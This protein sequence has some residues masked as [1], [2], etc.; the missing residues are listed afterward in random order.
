[1][2]TAVQLPMDRPHKA[3]RRLRVRLIGLLFG[4]CG[5]SAVMADAG[6]ELKD[7]PP[8]HSESIVSVRAV[9]DGAM[10]PDEAVSTFRHIDRLFPT[11]TIAHG[12]RVFALPPATKPVNNIHFQ[13]NGRSWDLY[14]YLAVNR[15]AGLLVLKNG[16]VALEQYQYGNTANTHWMSMSVAKSI[17]STLIAVALKDGAIH[18]ID[19]A[20][21]QYVSEL[22]GSAYD[23]V[24]IRDLL[25]MSS[26]V[27]WNETY[28]DT[29]S[30]RRKLLDIQ[31]GQEPG[32]ALALMRSLPRAAPPGT[33]NNYNTGETLV[34][35]EVVHRAVHMPLSTYFSQRI[36]QPFGM[37]ADAS[38]WLASADGIEIAGSGFSA[39]LRDYGRFGLFFLNDGVMNGQSILPNGWR[40]QASSRQRLKTGTIMDYGYFWWPAT[41]TTDTPEPGDAFLAEGIFGQ[42]LYIN[43][44]EQVVIVAWGARS[45]PE[46]MDIINDQDAFAAIA[47]SLHDAPP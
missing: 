40:T 20:V 28:T 18:S 17:T 24:S 44:R 13:S 11:R 21:T 8:S 4:L 32:A 6:A 23:G 31:I 16:R 42:F 25:C 46:G 29:T 9:Y 33:V 15:V 43:P 39:T 41:P 34:A 3:I 47:H 5:F 10:T 22:K 26:G 12:P 35:G 7:R 36:W 1:M 19:D 14:D 27:R 30:D 37:E 45:K 2:H 38:W